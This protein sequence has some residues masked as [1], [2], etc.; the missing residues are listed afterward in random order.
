MSGGAGSGLGEGLRACQPPSGLSLGDALQFPKEDFTNALRLFRLSFVVHG[1][2]RLGSG[3]IAVH[4]G[5]Y[6]LGRRSMD[7]TM[8]ESRAIRSLDD[9][10][11]RGPNVETG[12]RACKSSDV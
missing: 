9:A 10:D 3:R 12:E 4:H 6:V 8:E 11:S 5:D 1:D 7:K 2:I